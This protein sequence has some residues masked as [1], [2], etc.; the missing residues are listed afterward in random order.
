[1][2]DDITYIPAKSDKELTLLGYN[3]YRDGAKVN[4]APLE[5]MTYACDDTAEHT[6]MITAVY[7]LGESMP[8]NEVTLA[9]SGVDSVME[10]YGN[11]RIM[12]NDRKIIINGSGGAQ[13]SVCNAMG[14]SVH[15]GT[16]DATVNVEPGVYAVRVGNVTRKLI[17]F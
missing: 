3:V 15:N 9:L 2:V 7:N 13:V 8:S 6:Y 10:T 17:I 14:A 12:V 5:K 16:G 11:L 1:M 4:D